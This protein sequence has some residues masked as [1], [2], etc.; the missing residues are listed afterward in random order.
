MAFFDLKGLLSPITGLKQFGKKPHTI[1]FPDVAEHASDRYRGLHFNKL[2]DCIGCGNCSTICM[3][4]A[5]DMIEIEGLKGKKEIPAYALVLIT[6][7]VVGVHFVW[8]Y[9]RQVL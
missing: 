6:D 8:K 5:I 4:E 2:D 7:V 3:N 9:V 1:M